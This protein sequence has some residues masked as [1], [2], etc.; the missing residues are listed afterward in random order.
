M[1]NDQLHDEL[2]ARM[3]KEQ[4]LRG[5]LIDSPDDIQLLMRMAEADAQ[6]TMWLDEII[7]QQGWPTKSLV[8]EDGA[9]AAFLIVQHSPAPQFQKKC[10][11][12]LERAVNQNEADIINLAYLTDRIRT[13]EGKP[14]VYGTQ[15]QTN[16]DGLIIPFPIE[17]EEHVD[18]RR[19]AIGLEPIAEYFK[20]MN[21]SYKTGAK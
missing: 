20:N 6:N 1:M 12:L 4:N 19:K 10:L 16:A 21:E 8:G 3:E 15:G 5:G 14:Q 18:E 7:R 9:Q 2:L 11:E 13:F 17:D